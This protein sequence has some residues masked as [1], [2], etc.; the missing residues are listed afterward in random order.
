MDSGDEER[1]CKYDRGEQ[2]EDKAHAGRV[3]WAQ[4]A[5]RWASQQGGGFKIDPKIA[6]VALTEGRRAQK[7]L[8]GVEVLQTLT[9]QQRKQLQQNV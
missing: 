8:A 5:L 1:V 7:G 6:T 9:Y 3:R 2:A 4:A